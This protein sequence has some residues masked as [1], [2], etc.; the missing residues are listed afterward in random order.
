MLGSAPRG[1]PAMTRRTRSLTSIR[2]EAQSLSRELLN[3]VSPQYSRE[4][5]R[6]ARLEK[7]FYDT[8]GPR[9][10]AREEGLPFDLRGFDAEKRLI[11]RTKGRLS[12]Q[13]S[14]QGKR[15][16]TRIQRAAASARPRRWAAGGT[17]FAP[18][19]GELSCDPQRD[20]EG[21][22]RQTEQR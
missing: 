6:I 22:C 18:R 9:S 3:E 14:G 15:S 4:E 12:R 5:S 2:E 20:E 7:A 17:R 19:R 13:A 8:D 1:E 16:F 11:A 21:V 10:F